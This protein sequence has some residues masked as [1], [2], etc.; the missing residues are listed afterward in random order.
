MRPPVILGLCIP[1]IPVT[2][3]GCRCVYVVCG[4]VRVY[5]Q[6][7]RKLYV[8]LYNDKINNNLRGGSEDE[9]ICFLFC[10]LV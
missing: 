6:R 3:E 8:R 5:V 9:K 7:D 10:L 4:H 2:E 1:L